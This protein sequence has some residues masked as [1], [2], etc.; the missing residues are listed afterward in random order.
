M[1][2]RLS[3]RWSWYPH[4]KSPLLPPP[5]VVPEEK[6]QA[7][8]DGESKKQVIVDCGDKPGSFGIEGVVYDQNT[9][10]GI[11]DAKFTVLIPG[12]SIYEYKSIH[13]SSDIYTF[14][15]TDESGHYRLPLELMNGLRYSMLIESPGYENKENDEALMDECGSLI[16]VNIGL[17]AEK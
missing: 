17:K 3:R 8:D 15:V 9:K 4:R 16:S 7:K 1:S 10:S 11:A 13:D 5:V 6:P 2:H 14:A 12:T